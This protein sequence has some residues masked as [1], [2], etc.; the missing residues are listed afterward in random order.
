LKHHLQQLFLLYVF[1]YFAKLEFSY[2]LGLM[3]HFELRLGFV[4]DFCTPLFIS[5][6][7]ILAHLELSNKI[8]NKLQAVYLSAQQL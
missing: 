8:Y 5:A 3:G 4:D 1:P 2:G 7:R 6:F